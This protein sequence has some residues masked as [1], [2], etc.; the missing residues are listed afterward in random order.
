[1]TQPERIPLVD[2][3]PHTFAQIADIAAPD[4]EK[5]RLMSLGVCPGRTVELI[6]SGDPM[7]I[8]VLSTRVGLSLRLAET[9]VVEP[10]HDDC[11]DDH[12]AHDATNVND[13]HQHPANA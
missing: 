2:L 9:I 5:E 3:A 13:T 8:R 12:H 11:D 6:M 10:C 1:M 4:Q 7:I